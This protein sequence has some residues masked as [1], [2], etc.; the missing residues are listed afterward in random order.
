M[1]QVTQVDVCS[2]G[3]AGT[4]FAG[5]AFSSNAHLRVLVPQLLQTPVVDSDGSVLIGF[6]DSDGADMSSA[7]KA[8]FQVLASTNLL[9]WEP[10][11]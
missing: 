8:G 10:A 3:I 6:G 5:L 4:F 1:T 2:G 11:E 7:D 9:D